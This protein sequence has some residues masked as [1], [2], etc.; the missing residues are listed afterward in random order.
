MGLVPFFKN[1]KKVNE[2]KKSDID[3]CSGKKL[4]NV[5]DDVRTICVGKK[6]NQN[7]SQPEVEVEMPRN[8]VGIQGDYCCEGTILIRKK[9]DKNIK[10]LKEETSHATLTYYE[11]NVLKKFRIK[12]VLVNIGRDPEACDL[13]IAFDN[14]IGR[15][16]AVVYCKDSR[17]Y[18]FDL[19][20]KNGTYINNKKVEGTFEIF[21]GDIIKFA[22]TEAKFN[23]Q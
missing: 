1:G 19:N 12:N 13:I 7:P 14:C 22:K 18:I 4:S 20:S 3:V 5:E 23:I 2:G 9:E 17:Y 6:S 15:N 11:D 8:Q 10:I 21:D 16:H